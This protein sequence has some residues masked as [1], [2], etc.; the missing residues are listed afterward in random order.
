MV[1]AD[2]SNTEISEF[3]KALLFYLH[4]LSMNSSEH[5]YFSVDLLNAMATSDVKSSV[6]FGTQWIRMKKLVLNANQYD[7]TIVPG[8]NS[9]EVEWQQKYESTRCLILPAEAQKFVLSWDK[10]KLRE[11]QI[12]ASRYLP[13]RAYLV[14]KN[15]CFL[16]SSFDP[17]AQ[18][19][20]KSEFEPLSITPKILSVVE[21]NLNIL[22]S[23]ISGI[24]NTSNKKNK[25]KAKHELSNIQSIREEF[26]QTRIS[27]WM[28]NRL[29]GLITHFVN[30]EVRDSNEKHLAH[31]AISRLAS[32]INL[33]RVIGA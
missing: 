20:L 23:S 7:S 29:I 3:G 18:E 2:K 14:C 19:D 33:R 32:E 15:D 17:L 24:A 30:R 28:L 9:T 13:S 21:K 1:N 11:A 8:T 10:I 26:H 27:A 31:D 16:E 4:E 5:F 6:Y 12:T 22:E 25:Q